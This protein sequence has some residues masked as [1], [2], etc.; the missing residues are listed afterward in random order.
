MARTRSRCPRSGLRVDRTIAEG[1]RHGGVFPEMRRCARV[2]VEEGN[3][4]QVDGGVLSFRDEAAI[5]ADGGVSFS[6]RGSVSAAR[7][8]GAVCK[9]GASRQTAP[10]RDPGSG[11]V[12]RASLTL[13]CS[14]LL[15]Y[16]SR[17]A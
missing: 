11:H 10:F 17:P 9:A 8:L 5:L 13:F 4:M 16:S 15:G 3:E 14:T 7:L 12:A 2:A 1:V 6:E